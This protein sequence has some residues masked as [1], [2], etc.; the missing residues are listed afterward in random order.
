MNLRRS[1]SLLA[2]FLSLSLLLG[3]ETNTPSSTPGESA[4]VTEPIVRRGMTAEEV[5]DKLGEPA[6]VVTITDP[7][8]EDGE[9]WVYREKFERFLGMAATD[10]IEV[11]YVDPITGEMRTRMEM[12]MGEE[13]EQIKRAIRLYIIDGVLLGWKVEDNSDIRYQ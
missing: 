6:E 11:A 7:R 13:R 2:L 9:E 3:C 8:I 12:V 5:R 1:L 4:P 10:T